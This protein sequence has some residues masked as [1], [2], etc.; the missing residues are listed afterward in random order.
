M[1]ITNT[2][3]NRQHCVFSRTKP[4]TRPGDRISFFLTQRDGSTDYASDLYIGDSQSVSRYEHRES[5]DFPE[6]PSASPN[7]F[8]NVILNSAK[9]YFLY[10]LIVTN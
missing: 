3:S 8:R 5:Q 1:R 6:P 7:K 10:M 4:K 2:Q 9:A